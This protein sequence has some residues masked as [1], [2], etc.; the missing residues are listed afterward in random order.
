MAR[1]PTRGLRQRAKDK[2]GIWSIQKT[3]RVKGKSI[4]ICE[5][6][7]TSS[8]EE[9]ERYLAR[10]IEELYS[11]HVYGEASPLTLAEAAERYLLEFSGKSYERA[12]IALTHLCEHLGHL[13]VS[14]LHDGTVQPYVQERRNTVTAGTVNRE[15]GVLVRILNLCARVVSDN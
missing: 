8:L 10:R 4:P 7:G 14:E 2:Q 9:A 3:I 1:E 11:M 5:T 13:Q 15:L 6:T 12:E